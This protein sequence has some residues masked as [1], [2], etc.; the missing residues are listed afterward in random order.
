MVVVQFQFVIYILGNI[1]SYEERTVLAGDCKNFYHDET[2]SFSLS[3]F[4]KFRSRGR[5]PLPVGERVL[6]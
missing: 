6:R 3:I 4:F 2:I 1:E 5:V